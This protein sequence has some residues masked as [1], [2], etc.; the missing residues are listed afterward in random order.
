MIN[1]NINREAKELEHSIMIL[2][3]SLALNIVYSLPIALPQVPAPV[4]G[5]LIGGTLSGSVSR[6]NLVQTAI[7]FGAPSAPGSVLGRNYKSL[8]DPGYAKPNSAPY[9]IP[10]GP[11]GIISFNNGAQRQTTAA[12]FN[13]QFGAPQLNNPYTTNNPLIGT[14]YLG[15]PGATTAQAR[16]NY[17]NAA[18]FNGNYG[19]N[20]AQTQNV[21]V[22][23]YT[24]IPVG[25]QGGQPLV[26][27]NPTG[28]QPFAPSPVNAIPGVPN[29]VVGSLAN[30]QAL[31]QPAI[32]GSRTGLAGDGLDWACAEIKKTDF[33]WKCVEYARPK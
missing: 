8:A 29:G 20:G 12:P 5:Q 28:A 25:Q 30:G 18:P 4:P 14:A 9:S 33:G 21:K 3:I 22:N 31:S 1:N 27:Q 23:P 19:A 32:S 2:I 16:P 11:T 15:T 10:T 17:L 13:S 7:P 26:P 24:G 6:P